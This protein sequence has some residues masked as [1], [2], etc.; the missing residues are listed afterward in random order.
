MHKIIPPGTHD[1]TN[2]MNRCT[3]NSPRVL[4]NHL[5][6]LRGSR[7]WGHWS[8]GKGQPSLSTYQSDPFRSG[9]SNHILGRLRTVSLRSWWVG[10]LETFVWAPKLWYEEPVNCMQIFLC[11][12]S[13][14][15]S[16]VV[17]ISGCSH[18][19]FCFLFFVFFLGGG[20]VMVS[21]TQ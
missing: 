16:T 10:L 13:K 9:T 21:S 7:R 3:S 17:C 14:H 19:R 6:S 8:L 1:P 18:H 12:I 20:G 4:E 5:P 11:G 15:R 2:N